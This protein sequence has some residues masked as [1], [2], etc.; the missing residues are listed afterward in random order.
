MRMANWSIAMM[1]STEVMLSCP[2][3][4]IELVRTVAVW[5]SMRM[6]VMVNAQF[7]RCSV[8]HRSTLC[9]LA[10]SL[11]CMVC[12]GYDEKAGMVSI[13][14]DSISISDCP[15]FFMALMRSLLVAVFGSSSFFKACIFLLTTS[16]SRNTTG[17]RKSVKVTGQM[18]MRLIFR[19]V[20]E[21]AEMKSNSFSRYFRSS[22][23]T[24]PINV[25]FFS[26]DSA[27]S[28]L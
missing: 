2:E 20:T 27:K 12:N 21:Y 23:S 22:F 4:L 5:K 18:I 26:Q 16:Y 24:A 1:I 9:Y 13:L 19:Q 15:W 14:T 7:M 6:T 17:T 25:N 8:L 10:D 11:T 28:L 3:L